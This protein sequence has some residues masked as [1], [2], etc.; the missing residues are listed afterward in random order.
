MEVA[1]ARDLLALSVDALIFRKH[2]GP[3]IAAG[4]LPAGDDVGSDLV[5]LLRLRLVEEILVQTDRCR[6]RPDR[7][8]PI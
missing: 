5:S 7:S 1:L 6:F 2:R 4:A 8:M 3:G